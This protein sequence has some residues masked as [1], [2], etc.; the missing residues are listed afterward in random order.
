MAE[1]ESK[2]PV[3]EMNIWFII[4]LVV[5]IIAA[6]WIL[7]LTS[8]VSSLEGQTAELNSKVASQNNQLHNQSQLILDLA[9]LAN[10]GNLSKNSLLSKIE[11]AGIDLDNLSQT[12]SDE[13]TSEEVIS[14]EED[15]ESENIII[16]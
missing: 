5:I 9:N 16:E 7:A 14:G 11:E 13:G 15:E 2:K 6:A 8:K 10:E 3:V 12:I 4:L 1:G